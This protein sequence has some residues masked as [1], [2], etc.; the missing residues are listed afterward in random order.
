MTMYLRPSYSPREEDDRVCNEDLAVR[1]SR[2]NEQEIEILR[3]HRHVDTIRASPKEFEDNR[4]N[5]KNAASPP[6]FRIETIGGRC[7]ES[8][9]IRKGGVKRFE[10]VSLSILN[11]GECLRY[12]NRKIRLNGTAS[13]L[14]GKRG[15]KGTPILHL[16]LN[17]TTILPLPSR[18][19]GHH[20]S[21]EW[22]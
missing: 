20:H 5:K 21:R 1:L 10:Q 18:K 19:P 17:Y 14:K 15:K 22:R 12:G 3:G 9:R 6:C 16:T 7:G 8:L 11:S 2:S 4:P 13:Y